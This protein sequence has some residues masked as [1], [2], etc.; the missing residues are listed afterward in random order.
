MYLQD[1]SVGVPTQ[2]MVHRKAIEHGALFEDV[3][4]VVSG[5]DALWSCSV[6]RHGDLLLVNKALV[7]HHQDAGTITAS[8]K[9]GQIEAEYQTLLSRELDC[10]DPALKPPPLAVA[11]GMATCLRA[12]SYLKSGRIRDTLR[13]LRQVRHLYAWLLVARWV[14]A[15]I[16]P[17][18][19]H[20]APT[21]PPTQKG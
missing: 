2:V 21:I 16:F 5:V 13:L 9:P 4:G 12:I 14:L 17:L 19:F 11:L 3:P 15:Q 10:I 8:L 6:S 1:C 18:S 20:A 7:E